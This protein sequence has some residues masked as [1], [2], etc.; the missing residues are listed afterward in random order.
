MVT[1]LAARYLR[2]QGEAWVLER[3]DFPREILRRLLMQMIA[4]VAPGASE[5]RGDAIDR[6][7]VAAT[8]GRQVSVGPVLLKGGVQWTAWIAPPRRG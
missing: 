7:I 6:A 1:D 4:G 3:T 8:E 5:P 2:R